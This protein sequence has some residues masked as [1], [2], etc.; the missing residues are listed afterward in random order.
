LGGCA[1]DRLGGFN[2]YWRWSD[3]KE[4]LDLELVHLMKVAKR[5]PNRYLAAKAAKFMKVFADERFDTQEAFAQ[6]KHRDRW[7]SEWSLDDS[8]VTD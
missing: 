3:E 8:E 5:P 7:P 6:K 1:A 4:D 2:P